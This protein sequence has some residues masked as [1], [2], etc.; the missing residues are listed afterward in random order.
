MLGKL[1]VQLRAE[2]RK[3]LPSSDCVGGQ[4]VRRCCARSRTLGKLREQ[5]GLE[6]GICFPGGGRRLGNRRSS[7]VPTP[8]VVELVWQLSGTGQATC[9]RGP[10]R[11]HTG[12]VA[13]GLGPGSSTEE[14][15]AVAATS[16][17]ATSLSGSL[18]LDSTVASVSELGPDNSSILYS[19]RPLVPVPSVALAPAGA[20]SSAAQAHAHVGAIFPL[21]RSREIWG[22]A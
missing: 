17:D 22:V 16:G 1:S 15:V 5:P 13:V 19:V 8:L 4:W 14:R 2:H 10:P 12:G 6:Q 7:L 9:C 11:S 18:E 21:L 3:S 20:A